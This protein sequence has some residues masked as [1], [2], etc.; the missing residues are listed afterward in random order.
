MA[1]PAVFE[2]VEQSLR[3]VEAYLDSEFFS[4]TGILEDI[5]SHVGNY[6]GKMLRPA[7]MLLSARACGEVRPEH[8]PV[9]ALIEVMHTATLI[10]DD[11]LDGAVLRRRAETVNQRFGN[12]AS[13]LLGDLLFSQTFVYL[14]NM[15]LP[16][17]N[18]GFS[19][20]AQEICEGELTHILRKFQL[21][22]SEPEY[23]K[24]VE[25]KTATL[26][27]LAGKLGALLAGGSEQEIQACERYGRS[28]G[29]AFQ[30]IDDVIDV[31]GSE[32]VAGKSLGMDLVKGKVTLPVIHFVNNGH[33][34]DGVLSM[35]EGC[36]ELGEE[37]VS[38]LKA[39][40]DE[41]GSVDYARN[42]AESE[43]RRARDH[44]KVLRPSADTEALLSLTDS[45]LDRGA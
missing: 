44:L 23:M 29:V 45:V 20:A 32:G 18:Q 33:A 41:S 8:V 34:T 24:I 14:S 19:D 9:A 12:E 25:M 37:Q 28:L 15:G 10:H 13:V 35:F 21:D 6:R 5:F 42:A 27:A 31:V 38:R 2:S 7:L 22:L 40:L 36:T 11:I 1:A 26:F 30:I 17:V 43:I 39:L 3:E 16:E 4:R